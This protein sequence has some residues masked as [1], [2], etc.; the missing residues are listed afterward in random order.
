MVVFSLFYQCQHL[1][2]VY[3]ESVLIFRVINLILQFLQTLPHQFCA[4]ISVRTLI[5]L[6]N[7]H[8]PDFFIN[9]LFHLDH[10]QE[11]YNDLNLRKNF[12][13][14]FLSP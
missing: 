2:Y 8:S 11:V 12:L 9:V 14:Q 1:N 7:S 3:P 13:P 5:Q 6:N 10:S 4:S